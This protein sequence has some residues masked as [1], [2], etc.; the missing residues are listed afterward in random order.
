MEMKAEAQGSLQVVSIIGRLTA[1]S[2]DQFKKYMAEQITNHDR[3]IVNLKE[4]EYID[5]TGLGALVF[6]LQKL[7]DDGGKLV[8]AEMSAKPRV[9]FN[10]TKAYKIFDI[11]DSLDAAR[12]AMNA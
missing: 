3:I 11:Y 4:M 1:D 12:E 6:I 5:S 7:T 8:L 2:A 10:I 9:V